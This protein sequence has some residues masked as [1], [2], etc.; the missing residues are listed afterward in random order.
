MDIVLPKKEKK[1]KLFIE[2]NEQN[3]QN[4]NGS[5][6]DILGL[7]EPMLLEMDKTDSSKNSKKSL[8]VVQLVTQIHQP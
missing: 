6:T 3:E 1:L 8:P 2:L 5:D 7:A 4:E